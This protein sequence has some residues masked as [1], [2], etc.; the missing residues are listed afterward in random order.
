MLQSPCPGCLLSLLLAPLLPWPLPLPLAPAPPL[1][2]KV[3]YRTAP[4]KPALLKRLK[5]S[6]L[7]N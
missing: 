2:D 1:S 4:A 3:V 6:R 7:G 5:R